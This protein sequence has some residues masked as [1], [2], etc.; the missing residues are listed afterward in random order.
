MKQG[1][2]PAGN[3]ISDTPGRR[4][5]GAGPRAGARRLALRGDGRARIICRSLAIWRGP[6]NSAD[7]F[8]PSPSR[9]AGDGARGKLLPDF[10]ERVECGDRSS[11]R[12][13]RVALCDAS[14]M[15]YSGGPE[16]MSVPHSRR[17]DFATKA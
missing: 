6:W 4:Q 10:G 3:I 17:S 7:E 12:T 11:C 14:G 1:A 2:S 16:R 15:V 13:W 8:S 5:S 9:S